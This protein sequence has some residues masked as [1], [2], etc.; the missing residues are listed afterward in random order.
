MIVER[1]L[2]VPMRDG[3]LLRA[4]VYRPEGDG[5]VP[6][7]LGRTP[8]DRSFGPTPPSII[9]PEAAVMAG[10]ALVC[11]DVRGQHGSDGEFYPFRAEGADGYDSVEWV[12]AQPW[13][14]GAVAMAGRSYSAA[15]QWLA[16]AA[17][18][19]HLRAIAP[20]VVGSNYFDGWVYQ[21]GAFQLGF[22]LFWVQIMAGRGKRVRMEEQY[23]HLPLTAAPLVADSPSGRFYREWLEHHVLDDYWH[24][25]SIEAGYRDVL[26]PAF[27]VGGW[28][29]I[30]LGGTLENYTRMRR[31]GG[32]ELAR[33]DTRLL[34][35]PWAHGSTY[36][37]YPDHSF[38]AFS[39]HDGVDLQTVCLDFLGEQLSDGACAEPRPPVR[40]FVMGVN[41]WREEQDWPPAR[42]VRERWFLHSDGDAAT[43]GGVLSRAAPADEP[44]DT[45]RFDPRDPAP[46][47]GGPTSLPGKFL[48]TNAGPLDQRPLEG[49]GDVLLYTSEPLADDLEVTGPLSL[50]L[51]AATS[52]SDADWV[53]KLCDVEPDG[54]S[55]ILAEG[56]LRAR[57]R[58]GCERERLIEPGRPYEYEIDLKATSNVFLRGHR[59][60]LLLTSSSFPRFDRNAG[61]G[62]PPGE[63]S[64]EDLRVA[65]QTIYHDA[66]RASSLS[67]PVVRG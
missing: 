27:N 32:S 48:R 37:A 3:V 52:A 62:G 58:G 1:N 7:V 38:D 24:A 4:D 31:E 18:P 60:R 2:A 49:R 67:L 63:I 19:R 20:V 65:Q 28:Y 17:Q 13:C 59:I 34:V 46:T 42:A 55:R 39:P 40:I 54:F 5:Q 44:A 53:A 61:T 30:F 29:D 33:R 9:D 47:I 16:A 57:F 10:I 25:L 64:E 41:R 35:G 14:R 50:T 23:R 21:G 6:A 22:N 51:H 11:M 26:V 36:G 8:Y 45:Y 12:A 15:T 43:A 56:V 66:A